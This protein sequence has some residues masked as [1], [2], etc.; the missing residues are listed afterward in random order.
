MTQALADGLADRYRLGRE[1]G[2]GGMATV[3]HAHDLKHERDVAIKV[4]RDDFAA[5][6]GADRFLA[7]IKTTARLAHPHIL[8][9]HDSGECAG[10][11]YYV[12]PFV[13]GETL[14]AR[15]DRDGQMPIADALGIAAAIADALSYAHD[16]GVIHRDVKPE[17]IFL[18]G[19][20]AVVADFGIARATT[21][22]D[23]R[24]TTTGLAL[25]T[26]MY[27]SPEQ[28]A[29]EA[30]VDGRTDQ[31][32]LATMLY[33]M[34]AGEPP[35]RGA[36][37][38]AILIQRFTR[39]A[40]SVSLKRR[41]APRSVDAAIARALKRDPDRRF[42]SITDFRA[43]LSAPTSDARQLLS[44]AVLPF[45]NMSGDSANEYFS[46]G[47][48]E[49]II[50]VLSRLPGLH[51]AARTSAFSFKGRNTDLRVVGRQLSVA[52]VLEGSVRKAGNRIRVTA[53]LENEEDGYHLRSE[54]YDRALTDVFAI[55][56]EIAQAIA[57]K[58][59][60]T[61]AG[62]Y[63][64]PA[65][66][67][68]EAYDFFLKGRAAMHQRGVALIRAVDAFERAIALDPGFAAAHAELARTLMLMAL[69][70]MAPFASLADRAESAAECA[71]ACDPLLPAS[72]LAIAM[73][74]LYKHDRERA[75]EEW[76]RAVELG[77]KDADARGFRAIYDLNYVRGQFD[78]ALNELDRA[79]E[80]DPRSAVLYAH[81]AIVL[82]WA[83]RLE[84]AAVA[85]GRALEL[86]PDGFY[87]NWAMMAARCFEAT[88]LTPDGLREPQA[89]AVLATALLDKFGRH[90]W[91]MMAAALSQAAAGNKEIAESLVA[92]LS[93]R[94]KTSY[95]QPTIHAVS[96][97]AAGRID[98]GYRMLGEAV[99]AADPMFTVA[100]AHWPILDP[101]RGTK[102]FDALIDRIG[103][104]QQL[105]SAR[106]VPGPAERAN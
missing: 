97:F 40:P 36:S 105:A 101:L 98:D 44:I 22:T 58:L 63:G 70:G 103:W 54:R 46:D 21:S 29:G 86:D 73:L 14:R 34:I 83:R 106:S 25:G 75:S 67:N 77:P 91:V 79:M 59:E 64:S 71:I 78:D 52:T 19:S 84:E 89:A 96:L 16:H 9:L 72:H 32:A 5:S 55:Q 37:A 76:A 8:P 68:V 85:A 45:A 80:L 74:L 15:M 62:G 53:Q 17:N 95:V 24:M 26:P 65:T 49:E 90:P 69:F 33:E 7:E 20:H 3:Y 18:S 2:A 31:Y 61:L 23:A 47:L 10:C 92:E 11:L 43:A 60:L 28:A 6:V 104:N 82:S 56:D 41:D 87:P 27:M 88:A 50:N 35:F 81:R 42:D 13:D 4:L 38:E 39:D 93:A 94:A 48:S 66:T 1:L 100:A 99:D 12:M 51:V 57:S 102:Q 30:D